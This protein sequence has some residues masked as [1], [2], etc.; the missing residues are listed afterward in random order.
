METIV[1]IAILVTV[2]SIIGSI[3]F[4][5]LRLTNKT[6]V[7]TRVQQN[8]SFAINQMSKMIRYAVQLDSL[9]F[10]GVLTQCQVTPTPPL[11]QF[12]AITITSSDFGKTTFRC[13]SGAP[14][15]IA[16]SSASFTAYLLNTNEVAISPD[17][18]YFTCEKN[19][20]VANPSIGIHF[21][22]LQANPNGT[23]IPTRFIEQTTAI[24][25]DVTVTMRNVS[26]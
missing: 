21:S 3:L 13:T 16:S 15:N 24:P 19:S 5:T 1:V 12:S 9:D 17:S 22:L 6:N 23:P 20:L 7:V 8:G 14:Q 25:F 2:G 4:S 18:C 26:K 10:G 11:T